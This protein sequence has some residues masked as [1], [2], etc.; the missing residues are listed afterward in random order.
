MLDE[1]TGFE[2]SE[3][4]LNSTKV[5]QLSGSLSLNTFLESYC[6]SIVLNRED[7]ETSIDGPEIE[8]VSF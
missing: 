6:F 7:V 2:V 5:R 8:I 1:Y 3:G 4:G